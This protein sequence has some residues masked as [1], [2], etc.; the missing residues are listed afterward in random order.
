MSHQ[1]SY[2][3]F[4]DGSRFS[5]LLFRCTTGDYSCAEKSCAEKVRTYVGIPRQSRDAQLVDRRQV[6]HLY[7]LGTLLGA[8]ILESRIV[9][10]M[11]LGNAGEL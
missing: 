2:E 7:S 1:L 10:L 11:G 9:L 6:W 8:C 5:M 3:K 4:T